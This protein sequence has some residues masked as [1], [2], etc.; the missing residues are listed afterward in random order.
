MNWV[1]LLPDTSFMMPKKFKPSESQRVN[2]CER[3]TCKRVLVFSHTGKMETQISAG[4]RRINRC[5]TECPRLPISPSTHSMIKFQEVKRWLCD[6]LTA[7]RLHTCPHPAVCRDP[8]SSCL[9]FKLFNLSI[10]SGWIKVPG[11]GWGRQDAAVCS[12]NEKLRQAE[13]QIHLLW[14]SFHDR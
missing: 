10:G 14:S 1:Y 12:V 5:C 7:S 13:E 8:L 2:R 6:D 11:R 9:I 4:S 3:F